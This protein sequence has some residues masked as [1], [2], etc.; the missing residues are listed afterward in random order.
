MVF[1]NNNN[2]MLSKLNRK[3]RLQLWVY[4]KTLHIRATF[5]RAKFT[6]YT[7]PTKR[8]FLSAA[9]I[10]LTI[11]AVLLVL[12]AVLL[13]HYLS[14]KKIYREEKVMRE[15]HPGIDL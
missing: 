13:A 10:F 14:K 15:Y 3:T 2:F 1:S 5:K 9:S 11:F 7:S 6:R 12:P 8:F 4:F